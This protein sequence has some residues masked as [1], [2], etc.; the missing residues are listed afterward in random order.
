MLLAQAGI[1]GRIAEVAAETGVVVVEMGPHPLGP[2]LPD[3]RT[4]APGEGE[5]PLPD[6]HPEDLAYVL[7]TSGSTGVPKGVAV[8]HRGVVNRLLRAREAYAIGPGDV[9]LQRAAGVFDVSVWEL[10]GPLVSGARVVDESGSPSEIVHSWPTWRPWSAPR[11]EEIPSPHYDGPARARA[12][13]P[14]P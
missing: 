10:F 9:M 14:R 6:P 8:P 2:P 1:A 3:A 7:Y 4:P 12:T 13:W 5:A 11:P